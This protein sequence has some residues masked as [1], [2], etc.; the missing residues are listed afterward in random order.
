MLTQEDSTTHTHTR[1]HTMIRRSMT[2]NYNSMHHDT[3][4]NVRGTSGMASLLT[5]LLLCFSRVGQVA[6]FNSV[7][8]VRIGGCPRL[9]KQQQQQQHFQGSSSI[10]R[11]TNENSFL[12]YVSK[13]KDI[14]N[15]ENTKEKMD[16]E[17]MD[18]LTKSSWYA[19]EWFGKAFG[20]NN[21]KNKDVGGTSA[22]ID[23]TQPPKSVTETLK[24]IQLDN[25][26]AYFLN[27]QMDTLIYDENCVFADP[28]VSFEGRDRFVD[29]LSNLGSFITKYDC[30]VLK[31]N[32]KDSDENKDTT[33]TATS[34]STTTT[35]T[36]KTTTRFMVKLELNLP[37]KPILAWPWGV[38]Y[39]ICPET[40]LVTQ[41]TE[42]WE[43]EPWEGV[44][45]IFRKPTTTI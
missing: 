1:T 34:T 13:S 4:S 12:L 31:Q 41:H 23:T 28:F 16:G 40:F 2:M 39:E 38:T 9:Q 32:N 30:K 15:E 11:S 26:N 24:R 43:I 42:S 36:T 33:A 29:N 6:S 5:V 17:E 3:R 7:N 35:T 22:G 21:D 19:V 25:D 37:W 27:G 14:T 45:Q 8:T 20:S 18:L 10:R 44:K